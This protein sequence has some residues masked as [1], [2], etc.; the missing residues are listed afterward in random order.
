MRLVQIICDLAT[1]ET[2]SIVDN[3][4]D[5]VPLADLGHLHHFVRGTWRKTARSCEDAQ[6]FFIADALYGSLY[7]LNVGGKRISIDARLNHKWLQVRSDYALEARLLID[8]GPYDILS[9]RFLRFES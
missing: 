1:L 5:V 2:V 8:P 4:I 7:L 9:G 6:H 3:M